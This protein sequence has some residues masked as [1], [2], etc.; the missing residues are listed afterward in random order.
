MESDDKTLLNMMNVSKTHSLKFDDNFFRVYLTRNYPHL[1]NYKAFNVPYR[2][3][4]L[5]V[6][7]A[8]SILREKYNINYTKFRNY[9]VIST[10][11]DIQRIENA[12]PLLLPAYLS[13]YQI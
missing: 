6:I 9:N 4:Y 8:I 10:L 12:T 5:D 7:Y 13:R 2:K 3:Y 1:L 11:K